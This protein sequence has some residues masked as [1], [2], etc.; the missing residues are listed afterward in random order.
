MKIKDVKFFSGGNA[1]FTVH[2][3]KG[4]HYT[5]KI[6]KPVDEA[7]FFINVL[8]G[9]DNNSNY[10]YMGIYNP[11]QHQIKLTRNSRFDYDSKPVKVAQWAINRIAQNKEIPEGYGILHEG[12]CGRCGRKLTTPESIESGF[13]PECVKHVF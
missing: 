10:T 13:G 11:C 12:K 4:D 5:F 2:N 8:S 1:T 6:R 3:N 7:P 9:P